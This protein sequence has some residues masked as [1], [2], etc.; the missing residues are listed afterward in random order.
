ME[1]SFL[2][3]PKGRVSYIKFGEGERLL[4]ALHG[5]S[6]QAKLFLNLE[7]SLS[8]HYTVYAIDLPFHGGTEWTTEDFVPEDMLLV[9]QQILELSGRDHFDLMGYSMG[10]RIAQMILPQIIDRVQHLYLIAPDGIAT[11]LMFD[12][13]R[14]PLFTRRWLQA[15]LARPERFFQFIHFFKKRGWL[16][17]FLHDF[18]YHHFRTPERRQ[19]L[20][21]SWASVQQFR[22]VPQQIKDLIRD[23]QLPTDLYFGVRDEVIKPSAGQWLSEGVPNIDLHLL[24]EGHLLIDEELNTLLTKQL[25]DPT[26]LQSS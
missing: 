7:S 1:Y 20:F 6:D 2:D 22:F 12:F 19:R 23:Y 24:D 13:A 16:S 21:G 15:W 10:G 8:S 9:V 26:F 5:F 25:G 11:I 17:P 4:I 18:A 14:I 3:V